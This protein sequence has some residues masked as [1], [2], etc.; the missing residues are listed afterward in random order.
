MEA[1][2][3]IAVLQRGN[4]LVGPYETDGTFCWMSRGAVI[5]YWGTTGG[6]GELAKFGPTPKTKL[7]HFDGESTD[8]RW[9]V[10]SE[11]F[12]LGCEED[13]WAGKI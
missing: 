11:V 3:R 7:D 2:I 1:K 9:H 6:L 4:V 8:A 13:G 10:L 12:S 5:R